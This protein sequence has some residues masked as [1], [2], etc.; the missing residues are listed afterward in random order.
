MVKRSR[1]ANRGP[2]QRLLRQCDRMSNLKMKKYILRRE[3][4]ERRSL[5]R[6]WQAMVAAAEVVVVMEAETEETDECHITL[7]TLWMMLQ[8]RM[9]GRRGSQDG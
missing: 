6:Q 1:M 9:L 3:Y 8:M 5:T 4:A 7:M 2:R